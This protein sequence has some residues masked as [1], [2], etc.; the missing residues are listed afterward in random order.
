MGD[1][2]FG[3]EACHRFAGEVRPIV[4]D[5]GI[6]SLKQHTMFCQMNLTI[7]CP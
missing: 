7:C 4:E 3:T 1:L 6:G 2:I 5:D